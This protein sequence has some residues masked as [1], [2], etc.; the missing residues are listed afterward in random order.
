MVIVLVI[1]ANVKSTG[2]INCGKKVFL[3]I[4]LTGLVLLRNQQLASY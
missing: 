4:L 1:H 3:K 2:N